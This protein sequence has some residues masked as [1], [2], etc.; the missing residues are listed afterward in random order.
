MAV[1]STSRSREKPED[2]VMLSSFLTCIVSRWP[3]AGNDTIPNNRYIECF[4][5]IFLVTPIPYDPT[6]FPPAPPGPPYYRQTTGFHFHSMSHSSV[7]SR[8]VGQHPVL[9]N[10]EPVY[11]HT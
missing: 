8:L 4:I 2:T 1:P 5:F 9:C 11:A 10:N 3:N 7:Q 6:N